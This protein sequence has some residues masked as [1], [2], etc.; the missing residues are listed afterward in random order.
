MVVLPGIRV[1][2]VSQLGDVSHLFVRLLENGQADCD[3]ICSLKEVP[4]LVLQV[5]LFD[6]EEELRVECPQ[7]A[8]HKGITPVGII[9]DSIGGERARIAHVSPDG[10][11]IAVGKP[12]LVSL[13]D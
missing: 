5:L 8:S 2:E 9:R 13:E 1:V 4:F 10:K 12:N 3:V 6:V 7:V 11:K